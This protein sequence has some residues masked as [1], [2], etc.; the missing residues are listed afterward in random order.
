MTAVQHQN[1]QLDGLPI[2][3]APMCSCTASR[4]FPATMP[5]RRGGRRLTSRGGNSRVICLRRQACPAST[6]AVTRVC[7]TRPVAR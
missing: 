6:S 5:T 4:G 2:L 3:S 7:C 1:G